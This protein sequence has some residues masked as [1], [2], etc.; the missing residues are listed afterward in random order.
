MRFRPLHSA[1]SALEPLRQVGEAALVCTDI[2]GMERVKLTE[3]RWFYDGPAK[4]RA[5]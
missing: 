3:L 2:D 1:R 5:L 4:K